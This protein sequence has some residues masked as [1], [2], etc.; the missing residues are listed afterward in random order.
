MFRKHGK[1]FFV[2]QGI[3]MVRTCSES[4]FEME[5][6]WSV[7]W[8]QPRTVL[9]SCSTRIANEIFLLCVRLRIEVL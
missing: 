6:M 7:R 5:E 4:R 3:A 1:V 8:M 9:L 2:P